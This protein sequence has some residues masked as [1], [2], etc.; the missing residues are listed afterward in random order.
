MRATRKKRNIPII[1]RVSD[2][3]DN[4]P[5]F[6]NTPYETAV[7]EVSASNLLQEYIH[8]SAIKESSSFTSLS[9]LFLCVHR[10]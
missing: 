3:N 10:L 4:T 2:V 1:V 7:P 8:S 5:A 6:V 9:L